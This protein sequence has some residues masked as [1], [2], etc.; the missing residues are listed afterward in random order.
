MSCMK[1]VSVGTCGVLNTVPATSTCFI[2]RLN[3]EAHF[4]RWAVQTVCVPTAW[5]KQENLH[6][7][8]LAQSETWPRD[9]SFEFQLCV[10]GKLI[11]LSLLLKSKCNWIWPWTIPLGWGINGFIT[12]N[13]ETE[14]W[15]FPH[16]LLFFFLFVSHKWLS[17]M[18]SNFTTSLGCTMTL[19]FSA[20]KLIPNLWLGCRD[21]VDCTLKHTTDW[22]EG[23]YGE[24]IAAAGSVAVWHW[25]PAGKG[26]SKVK[27]W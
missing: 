4:Y 18:H 9:F 22:R 8:E 2:S 11:C 7:V 13:V 5:A 1:S 19:H 6:L 12:G 14:S 16:V 23:G 27:P 15:N 3:V 24:P 25:N 17:Q 26:R 21:K 10:A 20:N